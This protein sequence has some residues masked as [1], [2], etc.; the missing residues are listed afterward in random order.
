MFIFD[1]Q[2]AVGDVSWSPYSSTVFAAVTTDGT[3]RVSLNYFLNFATHSMSLIA[4]CMFWPS[5]YSVLSYSVSIR[6]TDNDYATTFRPVWGN[7]MLVWRLWL[8]PPHMCCLP[9]ALF[10]LALLSI[11]SLAFEPVSRH[12]VHAY[13]RDLYLKQIDEPNNVTYLTCQVWHFPDWTCE[14]TNSGSSYHLPDTLLL[15]S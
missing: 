1:L 2:G 5:E 8:Q 4:F 10:R 13:E 7:C 3:V 12:G 6:V 9:E 11:N 15:S 14:I